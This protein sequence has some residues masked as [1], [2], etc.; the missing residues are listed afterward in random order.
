[1]A[2]FTAADKAGKLEQLGASCSAWPPWSSGSTECRSALT[3]PACPSSN[4]GPG[5]RPAQQGQ[6][7]RRRLADLLV[8]LY[9]GHELDTVAR[10][11]AEE[12]R[13]AAA[14][15]WPRC[16]APVELDDQRRAGWPR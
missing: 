5:H 15:W 3:N 2:A 8:E 11:W 14:R 6:Q 13:P 12:R 7:A 16:A 10:E 4:P 9:E 1:M